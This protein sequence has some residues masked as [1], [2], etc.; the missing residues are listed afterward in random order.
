MVVVGSWRWLVGG[1]WVVVGWRVVVGWLAGGD[2]LAGGGWLMVN[3][4]SK[5]DQT[6]ALLSKIRLK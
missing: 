3:C 2:W 4:S 1:W 5:Q 6:S